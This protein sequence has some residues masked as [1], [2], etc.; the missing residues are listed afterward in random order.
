M[1]G[2][3]VSKSKMYCFQH[4]KKSSRNHSFFEIRDTRCTHLF[5]F[6]IFYF[7]TGTNISS[8]TPPIQLLKYQVPMSFLGFFFLDFQSHRGLIKSSDMLT[9]S[10]SSCLSVRMPDL[11]AE[12]NSLAVSGWLRSLPITL[13]QRVEK[14]T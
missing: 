2:L 9:V 11:I 7:G 10:H 8:W 5:F 4:V 1:V 13:W 6:L 14:L 12:P 3:T